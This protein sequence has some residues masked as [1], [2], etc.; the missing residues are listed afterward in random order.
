MGQKHFLRGV[1]VIFAFAVVV[2][3]MGG[4]MQAE[5]KRVTGVLGFTMKSIDGKEVPLAGYSGK[6][7]LIVNVASR[8]GFTP[9]YKNLEGLFRKY[10]DKGFAILGFPANN[11]GGQEPGTDAEIKTF[12]STKYDVTFDLF[13]K[14]SVKGSDQHPLYK[15]LTSKETD[16]GFSGDIQWNFQKFLVGRSGKVIARFAPSVDPLSKEVTDAVERALQ[17]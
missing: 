4:H 8:C 1:R 14:I 15:F 6:V 16:P 10:K 17:Q 2:L 12:C 11:F 3:L 7:L 5:E 9:Q 13:S